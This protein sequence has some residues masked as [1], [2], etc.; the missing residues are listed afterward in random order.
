[1]IEHI[2]RMNERVDSILDTYQITLEELKDNNLHIT[3]FNNLKCGMKLLVPYLSKNVEQVLESTGGFVQKYYPKVSEVVEEKNSEVVEEKKKEV[4]EEVKV[5]EVVKEER[6]TETKIPT[7]TID[8]NNKKKYV[9]TIPSKK[10]Y[11]GNIK[12]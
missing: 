3:D 9:G 12:L 2:V 10:P 4:V 7:P 6:I 1:M 8:V 11:R 5:L